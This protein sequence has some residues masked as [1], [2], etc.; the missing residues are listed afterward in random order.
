MGLVGLMGLLGFT[1]CGP[2]N[3]GLSEPAPSTRAELPST[4]LWTW[5]RPADLAHLAGRDDVGVAHLVSTVELVSDSRFDARPNGNPLRLPEH[6]PRVAVV[7]LENP[8]AAARGAAPVVTRLD[9]EVHGNLVEYL[10]VAPARFEASALQLDFDALHSQRDLYRRLLVDLRAALPADRGLGITALAS[11]C[12]GD[13]WLHE[14][15]AGT[16]DHAVPMLFRM[17]RD[18]AKIRSYVELGGRFQPPCDGDVGL[19]TDEPWPE[20][21]R[22][23]PR[24]KRRWIFQAE[25]SSPFENPA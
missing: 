25:P 15:P 11:W 14:L 24:G 22:L 17:G 13:A 4:L 5:E 2:G 16:L 8:R 6:L 21:E 20:A 23:L 7:R 10:A 18:A 1:A 19:S 3:P 12:V 9:P